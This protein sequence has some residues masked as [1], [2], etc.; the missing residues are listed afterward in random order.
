MPILMQSFRPTLFLRILQS[1]IPLDAMSGSARIFL[2]CPS[3]GVCPIPQPFLL[4]C[5][6]SRG[7]VV[8]KYADQLNGKRAKK[9]SMATSELVGRFMGQCPSMG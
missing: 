5:Q 4:S 3:N 2:H 1:K 7:A 6:F 9:A 8:G